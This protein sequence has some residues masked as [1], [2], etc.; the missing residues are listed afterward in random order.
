MQPSL[1]EHAPFALLLDTSLQGAL[2][3]LAIKQNET[4]QLEASRHFENPQDAAASLP[5]LLDEVLSDAKVQLKDIQTLIVGVGPGSFTGIKI[6]LSFAYGLKRSRPELQ[7][8]GISAFRSLLNES[9]GF[10]LL[11]ATQSAGYWASI[12]NGKKQLGTVQG[13]EHARDPDQLW[14]LTLSSEDS[15]KVDALD[16][17]WPRTLH[18][19]GSWPRLEE[20]LHASP[21]APEVS[22]HTVSRQS[23]AILESMLRD[24]VSTVEEDKPQP[25]YLRRST[26]EEKLAKQALST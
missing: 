10:W 16:K 12:E 13:P 11:P 4:W 24:F 2:I 23:R 5:R 3:G 25:L 20:Y 22:C 9:P 7:L 14:K 17:A 19:L 15:L 8:H 1:T 18:I 6:G 21:L 26:P